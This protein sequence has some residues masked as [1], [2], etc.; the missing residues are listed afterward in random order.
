[1]EPRYIHADD[2]TGD[3][4][5]R[6]FAALANGLADVPP[7]RLAGVFW[8]RTASCTTSALECRRLGFRAPLHALI[9]GRPDERDRQ[10]KLIGGAAFGIVGRDQTIRAVFMER[11]GTGSALVTVRR[12]GQEFVRRQV[13]A[14]TP[15]SI[16]VRVEHGG[17]NVIELEVEGLP[18]E[19]TLANN[20]AVVPDRR[21]P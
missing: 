4:G 9:T 21:Y 8:S 20:R 1:M 3:D 11:G 2:G 6:L 13:Q 5:T 7:D 15:F 16:D 14:N 18:D 12:D 17:A 19:L 10:I